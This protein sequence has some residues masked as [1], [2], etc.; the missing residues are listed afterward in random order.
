[1]D[2]VLYFITKRGRGGGAQTPDILRTSLM[3]CPL[4][5]SAAATAEANDAID[6]AAAADAAVRK[7]YLLLACKEEDNGG[8]ESSACKHI[9]FGCSP[10]SFRAVKLKSAL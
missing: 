5:H 7:H 1:M 8:R 3:Y 4:L 6:L 9:T 2:L 10:R